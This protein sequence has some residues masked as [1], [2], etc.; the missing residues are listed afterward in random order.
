MR[1]TKR[2]VLGLWVLGVVALAGHAGC[3]DTT[4]VVA[5]PGAGG[6]GGSPSSGGM[7][8]Q[9][10]VSVGPGSG[11]AGAG[12]TD[13]G[14]E[15]DPDTEICSHGV[16]VPLVPCTDDNDC[17][18]DTY[19]EPQIGCMPWGLA[20]PAHDENCIQ[21]IPP[22][23]L[24]PSVKCEFT[25][26]P[27]MD[28]FP[29]HVDVQGTPVVASFDPVN[30]APPSIAATFTATVPNGYTEELGVIRVLSGQDCSLQANLGGIDVD[31]DS[32]IDHIVSSASLAAGDL[33]GDGAPELVAYGSDGS[34]LAFTF[35][36]NTWSFLWKADYPAG[37]PW[38][39]CNFTNHRCALGWAGVAIHDVDNDGLPEV[40]REGVVFSNTGLLRSL[41]PPGYA[42][43]ASGL[44]NVLANMDADANIELTNGDAIWE[45]N[46]GMW[47]A[48]SY[49]PNDGSTVPSRVAVADFGDYGTSGVATDPE[50][51]L[52]RGGQVSIRATTGEVILGPITPLPGGG[53]GGDPTIADFDGDGLTEVGV[54]GATA[55]TMYDID[56]GS[57]PRPG[58]VCSGGS[59]DT[60]PGQVCPPEIAWSRR[61][62]DGSSNVTGSSVFDFEA[63][64]S[65]EVVYGDE[66]FVRVYSGATGEVL[67]SQYRS[68]CTWYEN[69]II[70]DVDADFRAELVTPSNKACSPGGVG[71][72][73]AGSLNGDGVDPQFNGLRCFGNSDCVS[74]VC[75]QGLCRCAS[76]AEC[77]ALLDDALCLEVG[78]ACVPPEP[79]T[80]GANTCRA[81]RPHGVSGIRVYEDANDLWVKSRP[82][83]NQHAYAVTHVNEDG[84]IPTTMDWA[85]NWDDPLLNNFRQNVPGDPNGD[86]LGDTTAGASE[87]Y[88]C[89]GNSA[90]LQ[91][92]IC[93]RGATAVPSGIDVGFYDGST[94][95]CSSTTTQVLQPEECELVT[96]TWSGAPA[97]PPG[98]DVEVRADDDSGVTECKEGN[99]SGWVYG[100]YCEPPS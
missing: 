43:Y 91:V 66:C 55:Y 2:W 29:G 39:P 75:D 81:A 50:I 21:I 49:Y 72:A 64:G 98:R 86:A 32:N 57:N 63:D 93:N 37:A 44:F 31:G 40:F 54:A 5:P 97:A 28:A 90:T 59:C 76:G 20:N 65:A 48:E 87:D 47:V 99:N 53:N 42:S 6:A 46:G 8:G 36:N 56:C 73:C 7:A 52:V 22:G 38:E 68:S 33:D 19:C 61:T 85:N 58:G 74:G 70:A 94:L 95:I 100:V 15:C 10:T 41:Q 83:W 23:V 35:K 89:A 25:Q 80:G 51:V 4:Q 13:C 62:Q 14:G 27:P 26:A 77:C 1:S 78:Y 11:G 3:E 9:L 12:P 92:D 88:L 60:E 84:T 24:A 17:Q 16:C 69:P 67:F 96:C 45:W 34:T 71:I 18:N 30:G 82:I 79:A